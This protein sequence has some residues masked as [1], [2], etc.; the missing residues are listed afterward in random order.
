MS[1]SGVPAGGVSCEESMDNMSSSS[2]I[3]T[4]SFSSQDSHIQGYT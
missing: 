4:C 2:N 1:R 3:T